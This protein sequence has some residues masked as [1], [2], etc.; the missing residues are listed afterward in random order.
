MTIAFN[1]SILEAGILKE[2]NNLKLK[3][4]EL[5]LYNLFPRKLCSSVFE[6]GPSQQSDD[7]STYV[8]VVET[9]RHDDFTILF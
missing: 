7:R 4:T 1:S 6:Q 9:N 8:V 3:T 2:W 5:R